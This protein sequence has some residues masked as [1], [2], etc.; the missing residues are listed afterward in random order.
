MLSS[1]V[2]CFYQK[3]GAV[4]CFCL[5]IFWRVILSLSGVQLGYSKR[6]DY[7]VE[8]EDENIL[9]QVRHVRVI[10]SQF[11]AWN[12]SYNETRRRLRWPSPQGNLPL[13]AL[14]RLGDLKKCP[15]KITG[16]TCLMKKGQRYLSC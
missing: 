2:L 12:D 10:E 4:L 6:R 14:K 13:H 15:L 1:E 5:W 7:V 3:F 16:L 11:R 8:I 9:V